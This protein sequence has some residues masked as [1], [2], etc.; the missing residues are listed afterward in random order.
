MADFRLVLVESKRYQPALFNPIDSS[1]IPAE[2]W[3]KKLDL[4]ND[5]KL[6]V[7]ASAY[8]YS[9]PKETLDDPTEYTHW[10]VALLR[11]K[12]LV[13]PGSRLWE[14]HIKKLSSSWKSVFS[15]AEQ[16]AP[17]C[18]TEVVAAIISDSFFREARTSEVN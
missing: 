14:D 8:N 6:S 7:Q 4:G 11:G 1:R 3:Y 13:H 10:D 16:S 18:P 12:T 2:R 9:S 17:F 15:E 5:W